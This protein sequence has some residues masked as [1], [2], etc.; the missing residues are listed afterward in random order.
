M[1]YLQS[2]LVLMRFIHLRYV[3]LGRVAV[4]L[5]PTLGTLDIILG[6]NTPW[7][8]CESVAG[9]S[10]ILLCILMYC[11]IKG[12][13]VWPVLGRKSENLVEHMDKRGTYETNLSSGLNWGPWSC[14]V[15][16]LVCH[17]ATHIKEICLLNMALL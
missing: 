1:T 17:Q 2:V 14:E 16:K 15:A 8:G 10:C 4:D 6:G 7:T 13:L 12:S 5:D 3:I 11:I 9:A